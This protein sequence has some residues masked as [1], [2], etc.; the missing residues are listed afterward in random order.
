MIEAFEVLLSVVAVLDEVGVPYVVGGSVSSSVFGEPRSSMDVDLLVQLSP[1]RVGALAA[2][3]QADFYVDEEAVADA[4]RRAASFNIIHWATMFK[5]DLFVGGTG[6]LDIE[7]MNRRRAVALTGDPSK[8]VYVTAPESIV[9]RKLDWF[10]Q[11]GGVSDQQWRDVLG[12]LKTQAP[13]LDRNYLATTARAA[14]LE[15]LLERALADVER[16]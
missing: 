4:V 7:Q 10:R 6:V 9:L 2:R 5:A 8:T 12:V 16:R 1:S 11:G 15:D 3:L 13:T 14:G